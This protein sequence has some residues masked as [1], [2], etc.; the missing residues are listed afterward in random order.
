MTETKIC[1][2]AESNLV[3]GNG[4]RFDF[5][6]IIHNLILKSPK[7][8]WW[9]CMAVLAILLISPINAGEYPYQPE[10]GDSLVFYY[11]NYEVELFTNEFSFGVWINPDSTDGKLVER[12]I[13]PDT[14]WSGGD[15]RILGIIHFKS[16]RKTGIWRVY[17]KY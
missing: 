3:T 16:F 4:G 11:A 14:I 6:H 8:V 2:A 9:A 13:A 12:L 7:I 5:G 17:R 1:Q 10:F 15:G